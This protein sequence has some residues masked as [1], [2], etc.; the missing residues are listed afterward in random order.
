[1]RPLL[2]VLHRCFGLRAALFL[3]IAGASGA[4]IS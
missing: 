2:L 4:V 3:L 1:M